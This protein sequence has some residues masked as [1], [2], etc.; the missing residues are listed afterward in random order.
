MSFILPAERMLTHTDHVRLARLLAEHGAAL[1]GADTMQDLLESSDL[2]PPRAVPPAVVTMYTQVL[3][4][5]LA[6]DA[7]P[8]QLTL[9]YPRDAEPGSGFVSVLSPVGSALLWLQAGD[10][11]R[12]QGPA[13]RQG[14]ARILSVLFQP[15]A[16]G[17][18]ES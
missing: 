15:E 1:Q 7:P 11:A 2:V 16:S 17:D 3:L 5:D 4:Q 9:C 18:Y 12:W 14:A 6:G 13:G 8:Y 10:T